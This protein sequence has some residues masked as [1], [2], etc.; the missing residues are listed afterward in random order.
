[1]CSISESRKKLLL[2]LH[3]EELSDE[4]SIALS[5]RAAQYPLTLKMLS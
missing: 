5:P 1:M 2:L 4:A 3:A